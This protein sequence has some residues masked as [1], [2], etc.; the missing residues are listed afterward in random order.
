ML[1][2]SDA[3]GT[4]ACVRAL[5]F[6]PGTNPADRSTPQGAQ[7]SASALVRLQIPV[8]QVSPHGAMPCRRASEPPRCDA[9]RARR[10]S[11]V[12][13]ACPDD[14]QRREGGHVA[15]HFAPRMSWHEFGRVRVNEGPDSMGGGGSHGGWNGC[16]R[17]AWGPPWH[18]WPRPWPRAPVPSPGGPACGLRPAHWSRCVVDVWMVE[19]L[20]AGV[21]GREGERAH[22]HAHE[23]F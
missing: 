20:S 12:P 11:I 19:P 22:T 17:L 16:P 5:F 3:D 23:Y 9:L 18:G 7:S 4:H 1:H 10:V 8:T 14:R 6:S 15:L 13:P 2:A 21:S